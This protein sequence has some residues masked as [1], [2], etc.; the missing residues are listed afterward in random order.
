MPSKAP[1]IRDIVSFKAD[2]GASRYAEGVLGDR[3]VPNIGGTVTDWLSQDGDEMV[4]IDERT[5]TVCPGQDGDEGISV[6]DH[7]FFG[8]DGGCDRADDIVPSDSMI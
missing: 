8:G 5:C 2:I 3:K 6:D 7:G 1:L 4:S